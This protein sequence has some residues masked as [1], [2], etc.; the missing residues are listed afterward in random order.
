MKPVK[1]MTAQQQQQLEAFVTGFKST[2]SGSEDYKSG[3]NDA[4]W[5]MLN[6]LVTDEG[7]FLETLKR[8]RYDYAASEFL[9]K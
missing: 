6:F 1:P 8:M 4:T 7:V 2:F 9:S 5:N 3:I